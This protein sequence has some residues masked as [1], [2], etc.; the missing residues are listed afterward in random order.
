MSLR[1]EVLRDVY[2]PLIERALVAR[3]LPA[4]SHR[5]PSRWQRWLA[6]HRPL[7]KGGV[8][9]GYFKAAPPTAAWTGWSTL[10][11]VDPDETQPYD[12]TIEA[13]GTIVQH[14]PIAQPDPP[15]YAALK[16]EQRTTMA[17]TATEYTDAEALAAWQARLERLAHEAAAVTETRA[18][19]AHEIGYHTI[20]IKPNLLNKHS[21]I[22]RPK[23]C[24]CSGFGPCFDHR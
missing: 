19:A 13:D 17:D 24:G 10:G 3:V 5:K 9:V 18:P 6:A 21:P 12:F 4:K 22:P 23:V 8:K 15:I 16:H 7:F 14:R 11:W 20:E 2:T 1:H